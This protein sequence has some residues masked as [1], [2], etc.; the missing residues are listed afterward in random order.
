MFQLLNYGFLESAG[1]DRFDYVLGRNLDV[2]DQF[3]QTLLDKGLV[4]VLKLKVAVAVPEFE[5]TVDHQIL[6]NFEQG[7]EDLDRQDFQLVFVNRLIPQGL[8]EF[9]CCCVELLELLEIIAF[10]SN[11]AKERRK[12][13]LLFKLPNAEESVQ[14][15]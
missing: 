1:N 3:N 14:N 2:N 11:T 12:E 10:N 5:N 8:N 13:V 7:S 9:L 4:L 15:A 6:V